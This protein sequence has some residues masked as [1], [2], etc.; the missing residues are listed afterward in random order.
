PRTAWFGPSRRLPL[1]EAVGHV[2]AE[3]VTPYPPGIPLLLP[4]ERLDEERCA[5]LLHSRHLWQ[6]PGGMLDTVKVLR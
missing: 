3:A 6:H 1:K 4:G 2:V 5:W